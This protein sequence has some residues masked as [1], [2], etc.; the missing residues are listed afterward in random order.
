M[1]ECDEPGC[2]YPATE[3]WRD[4]KVCYSCLEVLKLKDRMRRPPECSEPGCRHPV[5]REFGGKRLCQDCWEKYRAQ[6][7]RAEL[8]LKR[9]G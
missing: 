5:S 9:L 1:R 2:R 8:E 3:E 7:E 6:R 4:R